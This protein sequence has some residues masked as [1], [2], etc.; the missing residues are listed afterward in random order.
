MSNK[1]IGFFY[2]S[3]LRNMIKKKKAHF[4]MVGIIDQHYKKE[5]FNCEILLVHGLV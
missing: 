3:R 1:K 4:F 2:V 5:K